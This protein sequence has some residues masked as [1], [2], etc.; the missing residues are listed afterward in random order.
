[1]GETSEQLKRKLKPL[2]IDLGF[3]RHTNLEGFFSSSYKYNT[4][5]Q[6]GIIYKIYCTCGHYYI[7]ESSFN[8]EKRKNEHLRDL[9]RNSQSNA[10][11]QHCNEEEH[12]IDWSKSSILDIEFDSTRRK[13]KEA[14]L[15]K[16]LDSK[17]NLCAGMK[18]RGSWNLV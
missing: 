12:V 3:K 6:K 10:L 4:D 11:V 13:L 14:L 16:H 8:F 15:I 18:I 7:G 2:N 9:K 17:I 5:N 1:M